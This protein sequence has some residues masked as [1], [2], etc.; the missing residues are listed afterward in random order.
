MQQFNALKAKWFK[1]CIMH[2]PMKFAGVLRTVTKITIN[3]INCHEITH[4]IVS[5]YL[6]Q[7]LVFHGEQKAQNNI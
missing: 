2:A 7:R 4:F 5:Q 3:N 6:T 1:L